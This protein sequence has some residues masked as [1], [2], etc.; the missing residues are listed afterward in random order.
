VID[1]G[2]DQLRDHGLGSLGVGVRLDED[3]RRV[4]RWQQL[5]SSV[6]APNLWAFARFA[7][8]LLPVLAWK[9]LHPAEMSISH[10][11]GFPC[12]GTYS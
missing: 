4:L 5:P 12:S 11:I 6:S 2:A 10:R 7:L 8:V 3:E 9:F 1:L